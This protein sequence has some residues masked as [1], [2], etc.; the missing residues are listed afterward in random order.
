MAE[1]EQWHKL[2]SGDVCFGL[3][4]DNPGTFSAKKGV[5]ATFIKLVHKTGTVGAGNHP[6]QFWNHNLQNEISIYL[7]NKDDEVVAP[8]GLPLRA[9]PWQDWE[10]NNLPTDPE[11]ILALQ[12]PTYF[13]NKEKLKVWYG[14]DLNGEPAA[15][16]T[17]E[18][19]VDVYAWGKQLICPCKFIQ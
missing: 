1:F 3:K 13:R 10:S 16:G 7:T 11:V 12:G 18:I 9:N 6:T 8:A 5:E 15:L 19:C 17:N 14:F 4:G 2:N